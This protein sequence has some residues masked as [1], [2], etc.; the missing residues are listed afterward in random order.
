MLGPV[1]VTERNMGRWNERQQT[2]TGNEIKNAYSPLRPISP[3][4]F[5]YLGCCFYNQ[6]AKKNSDEEIEWAAWIF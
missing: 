6:R 5:L 1:N 4:K 3:F 2:K